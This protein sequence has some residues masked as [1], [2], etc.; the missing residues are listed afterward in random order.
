M[1]LPKMVSM[2]FS[3]LIDIKEFLDISSVIEAIL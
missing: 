3:A 2:G 1:N